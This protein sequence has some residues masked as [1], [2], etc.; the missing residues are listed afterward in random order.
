MENHLHFNFPNILKTYLICQRC[1]EEKQNNEQLLT[2]S[3][4]QWCS[5]PTL[6]HLFREQKQ[7]E[8]K[9]ILLLAEKCKQA[10][11]E[12]ASH[13]DPC[14]APLPLPPS[15]GFISHFHSVAASWSSL[16]VDLQGFCSF[17]YNTRSGLSVV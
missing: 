4:S 11:R 3:A 15:L 14:L 10:A 7:A 12:A 6:Q 5:S 8:V 16:T 9:N 17:S 1:W 13:L 2:S